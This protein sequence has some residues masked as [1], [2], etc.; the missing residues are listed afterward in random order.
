MGPLAAG[1]ADLALT[2]AALAGHH[3][4]DPWSAPRPPALDRLTDPLPPHR[5][6]IGLPDEWLAG[7]P[8][9]DGVEQGFASVTGRLER[10]GFGIER[11]SDPVITP[12]GRINDILYPQVAAV[13]RGWWE[14]GKPYGAEV[15]DRIRECLAIGGG[16]PAES[17]LEAQ[18][19]QARLRNRMEEAF[20]RFDLLAV[21]TSGGLRK[22]IGDQEMD[23]TRGRLLYRLV[24]SWFT[25]LINTSGC[26]AISIPAPRPDQTSGVPFS[27]QLIAPWWRE[28]LLLRTAATLERAGWP[29]RSWPPIR[30]SRSRTWA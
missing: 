8:Y 12:P 1:A 22:V 30:E 19:W 13:H 17:L 28:D 16:H 5:I 26:P 27:L 2:Y 21:P 18:A 15:A 23:T 29:G 3:P 25:S 10:L 4:R 14:A 24:L 20:R 7:A 9:A 6:R 11:F